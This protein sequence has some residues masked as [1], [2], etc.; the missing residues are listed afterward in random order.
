MNA[1]EQID[2]DDPLSID[3]RPCILCGR[4]IDQHEMVNFGEGPEFFCPVDRD[5]DFQRAVDDIVRRLEL[6]DV[7][8]RWKHTGA[9]PPSAEVRNSVIVQE[10]KPYRP[11]ASTVSA[12]QYVVSCNDADHLER[13]LADHARD[14][15][16]LLELLEGK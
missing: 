15:P 9:A 6:A 14:A 1:P 7:R 5:A 13:W 11:A 2:Q 8:D 3:P 10:L 16:F 4:T 12:F